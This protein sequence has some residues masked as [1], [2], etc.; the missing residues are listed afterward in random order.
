[1]AAW[2]DTPRLPDVGADL[3]T[4]EGLQ[5]LGAMAAC[6]QD[7][8]HHGEGDVLT[9][10]QLVCNAL[11]ADPRFARR[12]PDEQ[13]VL[14][15]A[16]VL[17]DCG[18][19]QT[20]REEGGR[21]RAPGHAK[22]GAILAR[23][24]LWQAGV[25]WRTREQ[26]CGLVR[27]HMALYHLLDRPEPTRQA[28]ALSLD[29]D[30]SALHLLVHADARGRLAPDTEERMEI[31][32][33][34]YEHY[35]ELGCGHGPY[36]FASDHARF[37]YFASHDRDPAYAAYDDTTTTVTLLSGLPG[38]GKDH[39][40][41]RH[42]AG[43]DVIS[44]DALRSERGAKRTDRT[45]QGQIV[46]EARERLREALRRDRPVVWNTTGLSRQLRGPL[47]QL[48]HD[49]G[50]RVRIVCLETSRDTLRQQNADR[51]D[52]VPEDAIDRML[53]RWEFPGLDE[54]HERQVQEPRPA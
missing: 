5:V 12:T 36:P 6:P 52:R 20:T 22:A 16:A 40:I 24:I 45:A 44:L 19:P 26:V 17:H 25:D 21:L 27:W 38:A 29:V 33:L 8:V 43:H 13:R 28:I 1:V 46:Q 49:Y 10:T 34:A 30:P 54:C 42:A 7:P 47:T 39:W 41:E 32:D 53:G 31:V 3:H 23:R 15:L 50:A 14:W 2:L 4:H 11:L 35:V 18:K 51:A 9:H 48:G 37:T